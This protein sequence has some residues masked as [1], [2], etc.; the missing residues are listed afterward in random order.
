[1]PTD[2]VPAAITASSPDNPTSDNLPSASQLLATVRILNDAAEGNVPKSTDVAQL[3][4]N[5]S[6]GPPSEVVAPT[7]D[8]L[9][10]ERAAVPEDVVAASAAGASPPPKAPSKPGAKSTS[11]ASE[12][13]ASTGAADVG[14]ANQDDGAAA[15]AS[16]AGASASHKAP[17]KAAAKQ[18]ARAPAKGKT[19]K[20]NIGGPDGKEP[21]IFRYCPDD[22]HP[23]PM[24]VVNLMKHNVKTGTETDCGRMH[25]KCN[26]DGM[27]V[28]ALLDTLGLSTSHLCTEGGMV[29]PLS[30]II[31]P[32]SDVVVRPGPGH[33]EVTGP[34]AHEDGMAAEIVEIRTAMAELRADA[35]SHRVSTEVSNSVGRDI[36][37]AFNKLSTRVI[38]RLDRMT[39]V[40][41]R[42]GALIANLNATLGG[43]TAVLQ[44]RPGP[45]S[46][47]KRG[48]AKGQPSEQSGAAVDEDGG[49][50]AGVATES[51]SSSSSSSS[52]TESDKSTRR[53]GQRAA[54]PVSNATPPVAAVRARMTPRRGGRGRGRLQPDRQT[55]PA[56][57]PEEDKTAAVAVAP[58]VK[59]GEST[60]LKEEAPAV[61]AGEPT[62]DVPKEQPAAHVPTAAAD[63]NAV[64]LAL[65]Q[66]L[67]DQNKPA[68]APAPYSYMQPAPLYAPPFLPQ[69]AYPQQP[70]A[71]APP[72]HHQQMPTMSPPPH[73]QYSPP[74]QS[75]TQHHAAPQRVQTQN[76]SAPQRQPPSQSN[77][78]AQP[79]PQQQ[80][81]I[82][83][84]QQVRNVAP[85]QL[86]QPSP[87][88]HQNQ[89]SMPQQQ[90]PNRNVL[91]VQ[92]QQASTSMQQQQPANQPAPQVNDQ[93]D[94]FMGAMAA[95]M[96]PGYLD[97][98]HSQDHMFE[99]PY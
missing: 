35:L 34:S 18:S 12:V 50:A 61:K 74:T 48:G 63:S 9:I 85:P 91:P 44:G 29:L 79:M 54:R 25:I 89:Q 92:H 80:Q 26:D 39:T 53:A 56:A 77:Q 76:P 31:R 71:M 40:V 14:D 58:A 8:V 97:T 2:D 72:M 30:T 22:E 69:Q 4:V 36:E 10:A 19:A 98:D 27:S 78:N 37:Q 5:P 7:S 42:H 17:P 66:R 90:Q 64:M 33:R 47:L 83:Q 86:Q 49:A 51:S 41:D 99:G 43:M 81:Q 45:K 13:V 68:P 15:A 38:A 95:L 96:Q 93:Q 57:P 82:Q 32:G 16:A 94:G 73:I 67:F 59:A 65:M 11:Q 28:M 62:A 1:M 24:I 6:E 46:I 60:K 20:K 84:Q 75:S 3:Q 21:D 55:P 23:L 70:Y 87:Q 52:G 88:N